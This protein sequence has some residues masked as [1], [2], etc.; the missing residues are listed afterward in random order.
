[1]H[2]VAVAAGGLRAVVAD[3]ERQEVEHQVRVQDVVVGAGEAA[4]LEVV[5]RARAA[6]QH[7]P[8]QEDAGAVAIEQR[9]RDRDG[10][11][12]G[13]LDVDLEVVL[14]V[15]A[16]AGQVVDD[17]DPETAE[18]PRVAD[19]GELEHLRRVDRTAAQDDLGAARPLDLAAPVAV[20]DADRAR[21]LEE[22]SRDVRPTLDRQV[23]PPHHRVQVGARGA[24]PT[25]AADVA[26]EGRETLLAVAVDVDVSE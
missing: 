8:L 20:L 24:Q 1:M 14:Q 7:E 22:Q 18:R 15:L 10:L 17:V 25:A 16:D 5:R 6:A 2:L 4:A 3:G 9:R 26:V 12:G 21:A 13:V 19:A 11:R 23:R